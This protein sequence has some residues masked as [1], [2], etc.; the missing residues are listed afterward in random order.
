M[1]SNFKKEVCEWEAGVDVEENRTGRGGSLK[2]LWF[3]FPDRRP[4]SG[5][6]L[7]PPSHKFNDSKSLLSLRLG[8]QGVYHKQ[9]QA[10]LSQLLEVYFINKTTQI[11]QPISRVTQLPIVHCLSNTSRDDC[12]RLIKP[13]P[14]ALGS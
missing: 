5:S 7:V 14:S 4:W 10:H 2:G 6:P 9:C 11:D 12:S 8:G 3:L 1:V 13:N